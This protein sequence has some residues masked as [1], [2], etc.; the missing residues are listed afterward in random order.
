[1]VCKRQ[2]FFHV[3]I[4]SFLFKCPVE[5]VDRNRKFASFDIIALFYATIA[6][7]QAHV[8]SQV[9]HNPGNCNPNRQQTVVPR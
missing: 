4:R 8:A 7:Y 3:I 1:M 5:I 2:Y 6:R 9:F